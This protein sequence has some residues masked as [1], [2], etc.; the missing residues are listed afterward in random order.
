MEED[1]SLMGNSM[2][3]LKRV[4]EGQTE[5]RRDEALKFMK[6]HTRSIEIVRVDGHL[7]RI[8][9]LAEPYMEAINDDVKGEFNLEVNRASCKN[10]CNDLLE[11]RQKLIL[12]VKRE[13]VIQKN[14]LLHLISKFF[15]LIKLSSF[16][17][18]LAINF[19]SLIFE[20]QTEDRTKIENGLI[21]GSIF[22]TPQWV[23]DVLFVLT[24][25][26]IAH[27]S[28]ILLYEI[29]HKAPFCRLAWKT[30]GYK[31]VFKF[32]FVHVRAHDIVHLTDILRDLHLGGHPGV[33]GHQHLRL[34]LDNRHPE[35]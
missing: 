31:G 16:F 30:K 14:K 4:M 1:P 24:W 17:F 11:K 35:P 29:F 25:I 6:S 12:R 26:I 3:G 32:F 21:I 28:F 13:R 15:E 7:E 10:K 23:S 22:T 27:G 18:V 33:L 34:P 2:E 19:V 9:F 5:R 20:S 8:Y